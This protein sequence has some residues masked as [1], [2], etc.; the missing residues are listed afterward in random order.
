MFTAMVLVCSLVGGEDCIEFIDNRGP[1][2]TEES[3]MVR[4]NQMMRDIDL[5]LP[6]EPMEYRYKCDQKTGTAI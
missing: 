5:T 2:L 3:C 4:V 6:S 1:Y